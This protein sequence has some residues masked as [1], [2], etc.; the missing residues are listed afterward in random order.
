MELRGTVAI[1]TGGSGGLGQ[2]ICHALARAGVTVVIVYG[3]R[4][5]IAEQLRSQIAE[6]GAEASLE[7]CDHTSADDVNAMVSNVIGRHGRIDILVNDA[8]TNKAIPFEEFDDLELE[9]WNHLLATNLTGPMLC[10]RAVAPV[11]LKQG[12][13]RIVNIASVAGLIPSGSSIPYSVSKAALIHLTRCLAVGLAPHVLVNCVAPGFI[14][15]TKASENLTPERVAMVTKS[16]VL[17]RAANKD[18]IA[19]QVLTFCR[20]DSTTGQTIV[21]DAGRHFH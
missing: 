21:V 12:S 3:T 2:R 11:M 1:V 10:S 20:S 15:G 6:Y 16:A 4:R 7:S 5:A 13:G 18:D 14:E 8:A 17:G 9:D 19:D